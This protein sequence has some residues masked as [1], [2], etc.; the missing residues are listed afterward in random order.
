MATQTIAKLL[1]MAP[2]WYIACTW[3]TSRK[4]QDVSTLTSRGP[5]CA[6]KIDIPKDIEMAKRA[7]WA[8]I[9]VILGSYWANIGGSS[10]GHRG[11][12]LGSSWGPLDP[13]LG[14][15]WGHRSVI[16]EAICAHLGV[17]LGSSWS[18]LGIFMG[19]SWNHLGVIWGSCNI[20]IYIYLH[21]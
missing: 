17:I 13:I 4:H 9:G 6:T 1:K 10:W 14:S 19:S 18:H 2:R 8:N 15:S 12:I 21:I 5:T 20:Y 7:P 16:L 3:E 11:I